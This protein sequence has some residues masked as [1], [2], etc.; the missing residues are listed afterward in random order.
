[1]SI[2]NRLREERQRLGL[3]QTAF[4]ALAGQSL[5]SQ[6][7]YERGEREPG[8]LYL[9]AIAKHGADIAYIVTGL[10][11]PAACD[12]PTNPAGHWAK[13]RAELLARDAEETAARL[14]YAPQVK[15]AAER[16]LARMKRMGFE[17]V[18]IARGHRLTLSALRFVDRSMWGRLRGVLALMSGAA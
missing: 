16:A 15:G 13:R 10:R 5:K 17:D 6:T 1:M 9:A 12:Q 4:A 11:A 3:T 8:V 14:P 2:G 7:R 18:A